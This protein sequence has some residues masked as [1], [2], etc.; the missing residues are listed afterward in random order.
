MP[1]HCPAC[2]QRYELQTGFYFGTG[3][4][5]YALSVMLIGAVFIIWALVD[6]LSYT[7]NSIFWCM[8]TAAAAALILQ[9]VLQRLARSVWIAFFV[10]YDP[11]W[12][13]HYGSTGIYE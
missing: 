7:D 2:G 12:R 6:G 9:P 8:G 4:V 5:S 13:H 1:E 3:Y 11:D 10:R